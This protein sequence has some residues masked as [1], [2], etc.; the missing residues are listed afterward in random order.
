MWSGAPGLRWWL[1]VRCALQ[2]GQLLLSP[3]LGAY[4]PL[5]TLPPPQGLRILE[6]VCDHTAEHTGRALGMWALLEQEVAV[7]GWCEG[8]RVRYACGRRVLLLP[9]PGR[10]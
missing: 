7:S 2:P 3:V 4:T 5:T 6:Y 8:W 9:P 1:P 10:C